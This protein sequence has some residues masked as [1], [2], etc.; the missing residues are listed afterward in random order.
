MFRRIW[1]VMQKQFIQNFRDRRTLMVELSVPILM[2]FLLGYA[3][4]VQVDHIKT[5]VVDHSRDQ[6]SWSFLQA[7]ENSTFFD[8]AY[9]VESEKEAIRAI[10][11]G[12]AQVAVVIP[13]EF[14]SSIERGDAQALIIID[15]SDTMT[16]FSAYKAALI[17]A[18]DYSAKLL[19]QKLE[20][21]F[22]SADTPLLQPLDVRTRVLY[23]P[24]MKSAIF[25]VPAIVAMI[26]QNQAMSLTALAI[27]KERE[28]GTIEQL[29]VTPIRPMELMIGKMIPN[30]VITFVNMLTILGLG[31]YFFHVPFN[32]NIWLFLWL[33]LLFMVSSLGLGILVSTISSSQQQA[34]LIVAFSLLPS[35]VLS[36]YIFPRQMLPKFVRFVGELIPITHFLQ[37][38]RGIITKGVGLQFLWDQVIALVIYGAVVFALSASA[39]KQRLE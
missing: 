32:G 29:L 22:P 4:D 37:I 20:Q 7:L 24:N 8:I 13:P 17:V 25:M 3:V 5:I 36:G 19:T 39:F 18:Q 10:D 6:R 14:T 33:A 2:L 26:L 34:Q 38:S 23:N 1:A 21:T 11:E 16:V 30:V 15:G 12:Q 35:F 31:V 28:A 9:Y 27:V